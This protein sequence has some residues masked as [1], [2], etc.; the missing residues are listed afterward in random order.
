MK[1]RVVP[2]ILILLALL[3]FASILV[4]RVLLL[5]VEREVNRTSKMIAL[6]ISEL[7]IPSLER[8]ETAET[9]HNVLKDIEFPMVVTDELGIPRAWH[10]IGV[11]PNRFTNQELNRPEKLKDDPDFLKILH[12]IGRLKKIHAPIPVKTRG[13]VVGYLY[14]GLPPIV[15]FLQV[16]P[17]VLL[18]VGGLAFL[19]LLW[20]ARSAQIYT[21]QDFWTS[22]AKGLAHQM[23][24]PVSSLWGWVEL[25][26]HS[27]TDPEILKNME[28]DLQ[29]IS[30]ILRRFSK[31]GGTEK[32]ENVNLSENISSTVSNLKQRLLKDME[33]RMN[34]IDNI[35]IRGDP[36]L[37]SWALENL[38][39][40]AYE[41][42]NNQNPFVSISLYRD[43]DNAII[44]V[45]DNGKGIP[46]EYQKHLFK[47]TFST[48]ERGWGVGL[49]LV[50]RI[51]QDIHGGKIRLIRSE[52]LIETT[53][54]IRLPVQ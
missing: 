8:P 45:T 12:T 52:P 6:L 38:L 11:H 54:E 18:V 33:I 10:K 13:E 25:L 35:F 50:R 31:I 5:N 48:K 44:T 9:I 40:N 23:G 41:A 14:Y 21:L 53:F 34:L 4:T 15:G 27:K 17:F 2:Y 24:V 30:S 46:K 16:L 47:R 39:K 32:L 26:K 49:L 37:L 1:D 36:E 29:R 43:E 19:G 7:L 20:A 42:R 22:F 3:T 28:H 51:I